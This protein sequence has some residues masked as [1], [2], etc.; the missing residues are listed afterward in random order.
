[1]K[2]EVKAAAAPQTCAT[3]CECYVR[4]RSNILQTPDAYIVQLDLPGVS[5]SG[6]EVTSE[7]RTLTVT[8]RRS[9][10]PA[11]PRLVYRESHEADYRRA[12]ELAPEIDAARIHARLDQGV[13]TL[14]LP[15]AEVVK[16]RTIPVSE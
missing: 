1:M 11:E 4:P 5:K 14:T 9:P 10:A 12:F 15:K 2:L 13:L 8:G 6:L 3:G 7:G 16:S